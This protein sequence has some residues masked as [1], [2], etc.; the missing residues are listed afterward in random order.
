MLVTLGNEITE[1]GLN[2]SESI[3]PGVHGGP[4][5]PETV[6]NQNL[7]SIPSKSMEESSVMQSIRD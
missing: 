5:M 2:G 3:G 1:V 4:N 7:V 6:P